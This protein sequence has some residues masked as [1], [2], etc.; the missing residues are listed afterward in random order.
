[1]AVLYIGTSADSTKAIAPDPSSLEYGLQDVSASDAGR[2]MDAS[3]TMYKQR[4]CQ[5][6]KLKLKW[7]GLTAADTSKILKAVNPEYFYVRFWDALDGQMETRCFY[8]GDR[9]APLFY[10]WVDGIRYESLSFDLIER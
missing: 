4:I 8:V 6:R 3:A 2:V 7:S 9:T 1:M 5:K 10:Y